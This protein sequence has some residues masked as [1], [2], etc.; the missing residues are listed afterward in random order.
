MEL[1]LASMLESR[2][3][4]LFLFGLDMVMAQVVLELGNNEMGL[5]LGLEWALDRAL[6]KVLAWLRQFQVQGLE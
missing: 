2:P 1:R 3:R 6:V 5:A 4:L